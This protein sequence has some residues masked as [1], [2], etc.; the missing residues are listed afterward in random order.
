[1]LAV[2]ANAATPVSLG[3]TGV[4]TSSSTTGK[5]DE[6]CTI[7]AGGRMDGCTRGAVVVRSES[8]LLMV[9]MLWLE[10]E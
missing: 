3:A 2:T 4:T 8:L 9:D 7:V 1:M 10:L 5:T 6:S